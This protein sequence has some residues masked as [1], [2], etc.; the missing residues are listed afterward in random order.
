MLELVIPLDRVSLEV[1]GSDVDYKCLRSLME[2]EIPFNKR[3]PSGWL[4]TFPFEE[5]HPHARICEVLY[6]I[7]CLR[8]VL[9]AIRTFSA[10][11][12][13]PA[14]AAL[15]LGRLFLRRPPL[16]LSSLPP[17]SAIPAISLP[18]FPARTKSRYRSPTTPTFCSQPLPPV[19]A[20]VALVS[21]SATIAA[22]TA[23]VGHGHCLLPSRF[24][25]IV[26]NC[27]KLTEVRGIANSKD[28]I[29]MQGMDMDDRVFMAIPKHDQNSTPW[30]V[31]T[32]SSA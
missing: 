5:V 28:S 31:R 24:F 15:S 14:H 6:L 12:V 13:I 9:L 23:L 2:V 26:V 10:L 17:P 20:T 3:D 11:S 18:S 4:S 25:L 27:A 7:A 16:F 30:S 32:F 19:A 29:L 8:L 1:H 22:A 21:S